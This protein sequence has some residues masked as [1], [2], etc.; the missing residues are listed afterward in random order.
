MHTG[1]PDFHYGLRLRRGS[2]MVLVGYISFCIS[3][4]I[5]REPVPAYWFSLRLFWITRR[6][7]GYAL[8]S[9]LLRLVKFV[10]VELR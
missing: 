8:F 10:Y 2:T 7:R 3:D 6:R 5:L 9:R 4:T 1:K